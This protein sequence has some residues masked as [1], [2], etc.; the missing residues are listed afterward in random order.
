MILISKFMTSQPDLQTTAIHILLHISK[1]K[2]NQ[3]IKFGQFREC[4]MRKNFI[5]K[6]YT[7][8]RGETSPRTLPKNQNWAYILINSLKFYTICFNCMSN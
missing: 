3:T 6:S 2:D 5:E 1:S 8:C 7:K 4:N